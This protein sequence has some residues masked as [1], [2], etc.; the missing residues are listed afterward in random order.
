LGKNQQLARLN[1][2]PILIAQGLAGHDVSSFLRIY[3]VCQIDRQVLAAK[4]DNRV[5]RLTQ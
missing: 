5:W 1:P 3:D 4:S 2:V